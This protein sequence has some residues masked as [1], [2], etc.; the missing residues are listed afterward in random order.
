MKLDFNEVD[1][2]NKKL[3]KEYNFP[4]EKQKT[5]ETS[6]NN[7]NFYLNKNNYL[8]FLLLTSFLKYFAWSI[9]NVW[10]ILKIDTNNIDKNNNILIEFLETTK[11]NIEFKKL[12]YDFNNIWIKDFLNAK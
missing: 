8:N 10:N 12:E 7:E 6:I 2:N 5:I 4:I 9:L 3:F 11:N 1:S